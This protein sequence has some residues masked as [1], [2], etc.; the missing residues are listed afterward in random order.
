MGFDDA[1]QERQEPD[2]GLPERLGLAGYSGLALLLAGGLCGGTSG[3]ALAGLGMLT[4]VLSALFFCFLL[5]T[6]R[7]ARHEGR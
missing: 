1:G 7:A 5:L 3:M 6:S 4:V 2:G